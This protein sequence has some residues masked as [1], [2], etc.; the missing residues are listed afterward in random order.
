MRVPS[1]RIIT[2]DFTPASGRAA[3]EA[4]LARCGP[5]PLPFSAL[6]CA[7]DPMA[8]A[9][10]SVLAAAGLRMPEDLS[11]VGYDDCEFAAHVWPALTTVRIDIGAVATQA[12]RD[13]INRCY[14]RDRP[15]IRDVAPELVWRQSVRR[16][17]A[18]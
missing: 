6:F 3:A 11:V 12:T 9:A 5:A 1:E 10:I 14:G 8:I 7:N 16:V 18:A 15:V 2:G 17:D 13:L 4:L